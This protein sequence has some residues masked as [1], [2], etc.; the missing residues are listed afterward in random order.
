VE[1]KEDNCFPKQILKHY[2]KRR[3]HIFIL[4][5]WWNEPRLGHKTIH[6]VND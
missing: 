6:E 2:P 5:K 4:R 1:R 3:W